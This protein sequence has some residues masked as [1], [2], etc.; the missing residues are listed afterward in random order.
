MSRAPAFLISLIVVFSFLACT[1]KASKKTALTDYITEN[2]TSVWRIDDWSNYNALV[3]SQYATN[4][5]EDSSEVSRLLRHLQPSKTSLITAIATESDFHYVIIA[6]QD[7]LLL[8]T[9][10]TKYNIQK[11]QSLTKYTDNDYSFYTKIRDS[12]VLIS[13][14]ETALETLLL[15]RKQNNK[16][17][18]RLLK[19]KSK[20][21]IVG[22]RK[23][24]KTSGLAAWSVLDF[25]QLKDGFL[26]TG[27]L[28]SND[29][30]GYWSNLIVGQKP[31]P[32]Q[33]AEYTPI[34]ANAAWA[35][36][37]QNTEQ[38]KKQL[39]IYTK[40]T[41]STK[42]FDLLEAS[43]ELSCINLPSGS[44]F[45]VNSLDKETLLQLLITDVNLDETYREMPIYAVENK[46]LLENVKQ[47]FCKD[48]A[49][50]YL[51]ILDRYFIFV[52]N[53][54]LAK[55]FITTQINQHSLAKTTAYKESAKT[56]SSNA[57][58]V[59]YALDGNMPKEL[60][61]QT[62]LEIFGSKSHLNKSQFP[63][64]SLQLNADTGFSHIN[65]LAHQGS[66]QNLHSTRVTEKLQIK[67][68]ERILKGPIYFSNHLTH[69]KDI[70][71]QDQ[72]NT[73]HLYNSEN[74]NKYWSKS[75]DSPILG[76]IHEIDLYKNGRKQLAFATENGLYILAR[77]GKE[78]APFPIKF[79]DKVTQGLAVFDYN[80][81]SDYRFVII[82]GEDV[83]MYNNKANLVR[84]FTY[85]KAAS[86][87]IMPAQHLRIGRRDYLIFAEENGKLQIRNRRGQTRITVAG[88]YD[89][90]PQP[91]E[92]EQ[93][94]FVFYTNSLEKIN[95]STSGTI[96][97]QTLNE[98]FYKTTK[99]GVTAFIQAQNLRINQTKIELPFGLYTHPE[100]YR[101]G[102]QTYVTLTDTQESRVY[103]YNAKGDLL[104][105]FPVYGKNLAFLADANRNGKPNLIVQTDDDTITQ[106][107]VE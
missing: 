49:I 16:E 101:L 80:N 96:K 48:L 41:V 63:L 70:L 27:I 94:G 31:Q 46:Q 42:E 6:P 86:K 23:N 1:K 36:G 5:T 103:V 79:K 75:L 8:P 4:L 7:S 39:E 45:G 33:L 95:L 40:N 19:V 59:Y 54:D 74:G 65:F 66:E 90:K 35:I 97:K 58:L 93:D 84:G 3:Q 55:E 51:V 104:Q 78:V 60:Q 11:Q 15:D 69:G 26:A 98:P 30:L 87:L 56:L 91:V 88:K 77:N 44:A 105:G 92:I 102:N 73:L 57:S 89:I 14:D 34:H 68:D 22:L 62:A 37:Y 83:L 2:T 24:T 32:I 76:E 25:T 100:I 85:T 20:S 71:V 53:K 10:T 17:L 82:Q 43:D 18:K 9:D 72:T 99:H 106:Y 107:S 38:L 81:N 13:T 61:K 29:S 50:N 47:A 64:L 28:Q 21:N 67:L 52:A 12:I